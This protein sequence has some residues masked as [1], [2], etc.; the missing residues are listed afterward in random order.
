VKTRLCAALIGFAVLGFWQ[1]AADL[2]WVSPVLL[3]APLDIGAFL[4]EALC[5]GTLL[6]ALGVTLSRLLIGYGAGLILGI[7]LGLLFYADAL[8]RATLGVL[9][10][11][12]QTL[13]SICW[14]P[15]SL[16]WFGQSEQAM[17]FVVI[18][19]STWAV[20]L[21]VDNALKSVPRQYIQAARVM[22]SKGAHTWYTVMLPAAL[23]QLVSGAKLGWAFSWR[24]LMAA[25]IY[26]TI[27]TRPGLGQLLHFGRELNAM[28]QAVGVMITIVLTGFLV[29]RAVF[30]PIEQHLA[31]AWA[32]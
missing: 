6:Q 15:L 19:G 13:P 4:L 21:A 8:A 26:V 11:G 18:M 25:E 24:S 5:D 30:Q 1:T 32:K 10:L 9:A 3:P 12:L 29:D 2:R 28:D 14:A 23:P 16:L 20:A 7:V 17:Y 27:I 22:G 31:R